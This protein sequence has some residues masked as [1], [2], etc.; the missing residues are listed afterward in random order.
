MHVSL[1]FKMCNSVFHTKSEF[2]RN[3]QDG[4]CTFKLELVRLHVTLLELV[5]LHVTFPCQVF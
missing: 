2:V 3:F 5:R 1:L 4:H